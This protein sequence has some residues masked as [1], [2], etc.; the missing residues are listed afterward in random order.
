[1]KILRLLV[2]LAALALVLA[3]AGCGGGGGEV[4]ADA[5]AVVDGEEVSR[6]EYEGLL[7]QARKGY[8]NRSQE[9]PAAG[10]REFQ[11]LKNQAVQ[12]LVQRVQFRQQAEELEIAVTEKD[13]DRRLE[14]IKKQYFGGDEKK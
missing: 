12:Y 6:A 14:Q 4:P 5:V 2:L 11:T 1:M 10:T 7:E 13:V 3:A 9:F 8:K